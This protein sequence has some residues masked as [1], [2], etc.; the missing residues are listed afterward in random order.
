[1][2]VPQ[3]Q[4][5]ARWKRTMPSTSTAAP[6]GF[7]SFE[8]IMPRIERAGALPL[9]LS[10]LLPNR[11]HNESLLGLIERAPACRM[12][13]RPLC[14]V[15][16]ADP[17]LNVELLAERLRS[18]GCRDLVNL[19]SAS[20]YGSAFRSIL[21]NLKVGPNR[22]FRTLARFSALSFAVSVAVAR[23]EDVA[24][25]LA[26][27]PP[28]LFVVPS[29]DD[30]DGVSIN[31]GGLLALCRAVAERRDGLAPDVPICL[32]VEGST[33]SLDEAHAAGADGGIL[34]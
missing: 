19:P 16:A 2:R 25:A 22:E 26:L 29:L 17:F 6:D 32:S 13:E 10:G 31:G 1:M 18:K 24:G 12:G 9:D 11:D 5:A 8:I 7:R 27:A 30:W 33:I 15:F 4:I 21:D 3:P 23:V 28:R 20:Q 34:I 14:A